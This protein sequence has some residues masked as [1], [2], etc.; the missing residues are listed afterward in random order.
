MQRVQTIAGIESGHYPR[1]A[2]SQQIQSCVVHSVVIHSWEQPTGSTND[3]EGTDRPHRARRPRG[4]Q[5]TE[6]APRKGM[7]GGDGQ[8][9]GRCR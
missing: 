8:P 9:D 6:R 7:A 2:F 1:K 4:T 3:A 5:G